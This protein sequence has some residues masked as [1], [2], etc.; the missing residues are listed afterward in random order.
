LRYTPAMAANLTTS[1][2]SL[3]DLLLASTE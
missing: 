2:W 3:K 1:V